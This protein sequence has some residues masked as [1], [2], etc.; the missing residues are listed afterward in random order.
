MLSLLQLA[1]VSTL[2]AGTLCKPYMTQELV[3]RINHDPTLHWKAKLYPRF[4]GLSLEEL[5]AQTNGAPDVFT[6][7]LGPDARSTTYVPPYPTDDLPESY[8]PMDEH[9]ECIQPALDQGACGNCYSL[10]TVEAFSDL[11]CLHGLD[12]E[13]V[14]YSGAYSTS[15]DR[16]NGGCNGG[17]VYRV[18]TF[19]TGHGDVPDSCLPYN[20]LG[21]DLGHCPSTC[22][23]GSPLPK[24]VH[25][26]GW[27]NIGLSQ[28][29]GY[30]TIMASLV[31][32]GPAVTCFLICPDFNAYESG[33]YSPLPD[34]YCGSAHCMEI[35]GYGVSHEDGDIHYWILKNSWG[36][37]WG[38]GGFV[39][40]E[41][42]SPMSQLEDD[43]IEGYVD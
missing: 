37:D 10:S 28:G 2:L 32:N 33:I 15:C 18:W 29:F 20:E 6:R 40:F 19:L 5:R 39:R 4:A 41:R 12:T 31:Y 17:V 9:P 25:A 27:H 7:N 21:P 11:R 34:Q 8:N 24:L 43:V 16:E 26:K 13:P 3:D 38:E 14:L 36:P 1:L 42:G 30:E 23:D 22:A 35:V